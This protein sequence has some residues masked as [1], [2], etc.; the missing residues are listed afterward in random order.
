MFYMISISEYGNT[1]HWRRHEWH[2]H[3]KRAACAFG[4]KVLG[5]LKIHSHRQWRHLLHDALHA[6]HLIEDCK[7]VVPETRQQ[8]RVLIDLELCHV[9]FELIEDGII[10]L[11]ELC[12]WASDHAN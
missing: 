10:L 5:K 6:A 4:Q 9:L 12:N 3:W 11:K 7:D 8:V 2:A 1:W